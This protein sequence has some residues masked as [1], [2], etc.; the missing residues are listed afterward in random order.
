M[1]S[2]LKGIVGFTA[3]GE[4]LEQ[5]VGGNIGGDTIESGYML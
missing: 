1:V 2:E 5:V 3:A 4:R